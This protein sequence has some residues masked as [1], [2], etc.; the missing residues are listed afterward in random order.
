[1]I[2]NYEEYVNLLIYAKN[3]EIIIV[4]RAMMIIIPFHVSFRTPEVRSVGLG[5]H[6]KKLKVKMKSLVLEHISTKV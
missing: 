6:T 5:K 2:L 1:M 4:I 3:C